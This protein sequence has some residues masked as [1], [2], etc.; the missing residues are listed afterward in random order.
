MKRNEPLATDSAIRVPCHL[1]SKRR[2]LAALAQR[3]NFPDYFAANWDAFEECLTD[4][5]PPAG[6]GPLVLV[7][8]GVPFPADARQRRIYLAIL[9]DVVAARPA[10]LQVVF[11]QSAAAAIRR[12]L[13]G[14]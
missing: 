9:R 5:K 11:P 4:A 10:A 14:S 8:D 7:H 6:G 13:R 3:L 1:N 2:L 12:S